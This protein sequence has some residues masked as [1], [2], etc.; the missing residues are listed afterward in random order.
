M[1]KYRFRGGVS[2]G[3]RRER[4]MTDSSF[5]REYEINDRD[6]INHS[7]I[8]DG[9]PNKWIFKHNPITDEQDVFVRTEEGLELVQVIGGSVKTDR[10]ILNSYGTLSYTNDIS[11][12]VF[13]E[14]G[15]V[16]YTRALDVIH[17]GDSKTDKE[18]DILGP[19]IAS[20]PLEP[21]T[22]R[23][24]NDSFDETFIIDIDN[25]LSFPLIT[26]NFGVSNILVITDLSLETVTPEAEISKIRITLFKDDEV[27]VSEP[28]ILDYHRGKGLDF[29]LV[30]EPAIGHRNL[31]LT[32]VHPIPLEPNTTYTAE[33]ASLSPLEIHG[34]TES[35]EGDDFFI[36]HAHFI[37]ARFNRNPIV[38]GAAIFCTDIIPTDLIS[39]VV[40]T[41]AP[42]PNEEVVNSI[43]TSTLNLT[44]DVEWDRGS[45]YEGL[46]TV[47]DVP[48]TN[49]TGT[50]PYF[51]NVDITVLATDTSIDLDVNGINSAVL[52]EIATPPV[53][54]SA[55]LSGVF[56]GSQ[57]ELKAGDVITM[58]V[59]TD[60]PV[61]RVNY[62][63]GL[64][65]GSSES[66][67][68][69]DNFTVNLTVTNTSTLATQLA[70]TFTVTDIATSDPFVT[71]NT[72]LHNNL[73]PSVSIDSI[74]YPATQS[75]LKNLESATIN[76]TVTDFDTISYTSP[77]SELDIISP[78]IYNVA[79]VV[80]RNSGIYNVSTDNFTITAIRTA[81][82][83]TTVDSSVVNI[84]NVTPLISVD[85][86]SDPLRSGG[87]DGTTLPIYTVTL[88]SDQ[89]IQTNP[90]LVNSSGTFAGTEFT[91]TPTSTIFTRGLE[92]SDVDIKGSHSFS[93]LV[94]TGLAGLPVTVITGSP[95]YSL[96]GFIKRNITIPALGTDA[97][98]N[99]DIVDETKVEVFWQFTNQSLIRSLT[100]VSPQVNKFY[101]MNAPPLTPAIKLLDT[102]ATNASLQ[103]SIVEIEEIT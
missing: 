49:V 75:A 17:I 61:S 47:N 82:D 81:N 70:Q 23:I 15:I 41:R 35:I 29:E 42:V 77:T 96:V 59:V 12:D 71:S 28:S 84:A 13:S 66:F 18:I 5:N 43:I 10:V 14:I 44:V 51:A 94:A 36:P 56:P 20:R 46:P 52:L 45:F 63:S 4:D 100:P 22:D 30:G 2:N 9:L 54:L 68:A 60:I 16:G 93:N 38:S 74:V 33:I 48:V 19:L 88:T 91:W 85:V 92:V 103:S 25:T 73:R 97:I 8:E 1:P 98:I 101:I 79:K 39:P 58:D 69:S 64:A 31:V 86:G 40:L 57:T 6:L 11:D 80:T 65:S 89:R 24:F 53:I 78:T 62:I 83:S 27:V 50:N 21:F 99:V 90:T 67:V 7:Q 87:N 37:A 102:L 3:N 32:L 34:S 76:N 72:M 55:A 26:S 95:S